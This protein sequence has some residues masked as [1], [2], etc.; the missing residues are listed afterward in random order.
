MKRVLWS[1]SELFIEVRWKQGDLQETDEEVEEPVGSSGESHAATAVLRGIHLSDDSPDKGTPCGSEGNNGQAGE[2]NEDGTG[3]GGVERVLTVESE[4]ANE[5]V[6]EE[7]HHHPGGTDH[8]RLSATTLLDDVETAEGTETVDRAE[9]E[10]GDVAVLETGGSKDGGTEVEEEVDTSELLTSLEDDTEDGAVHHALASEDVDKA[11]GGERV[12]FVKLLLD[13]G[14]LTVNTR[15]VDV[16]TS[17]VGDGLS[18]LFLLT[19]SVGKSGR[20]GKQKDTSSEEK[21]PEEVETV[22]NS[23]GSTASVVI[24]SPVD[25]LSTPDTKCNKE[26]VA[27][28]DKTS[29][30]S[31]ST[32]GLVHGNSNRKST[33]TKTCN[34]STNSVLVP[35]VLRSDLDNS[36]N[37]SRQGGDR[38]GHA[39]TNAITEIAG[40]KR[41]K[42]AAN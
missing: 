8:Q 36:S 20:L 17:K 32:L 41:A 6:D 14:D 15:G 42:K 9:N 26:L 19:L 1:V 39:T 25:H 11:G 18:G 40:D 5:G 27:R 33:D 38:D 35:G 23:P 2:G 29:D 13:I 34:Q 10:L 31:R 3:C 16:E 22:G 37:A 7:A 30:D 4:V 21:G 12:L 28:D 24:G